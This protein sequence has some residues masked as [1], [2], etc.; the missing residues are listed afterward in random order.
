EIALARGKRLYDKRQT[1]RERDAQ[2]EVERALS[3][4]K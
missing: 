3:Q 1:I 4:R 2:R